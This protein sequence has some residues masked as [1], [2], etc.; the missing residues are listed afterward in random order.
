MPVS[1]ISR[2][3]IVAVSA[4]TTRGDHLRQAG[5]RHAQHLE[6]HRIPIARVNIEQQSP[7]RVGRI[8]NMRFA[9]RKLPGKPTVDG[10]EGELAALGACAR[11]P[12]RCPATRRAWCRRSTDRAADRFVLR[13]RVQGPRLSN[14]RNR[15]RCARFLP[16]NG[17]RDWRAGLAIPQYGRFALI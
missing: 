4:G 5:T 3:W 7:A 8:G 14:A 15:A 16:D 1:G 10:A 6:Q 13:S 17:V 12:A 9:A 2:R 11:L